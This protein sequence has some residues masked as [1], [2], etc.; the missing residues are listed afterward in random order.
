VFV[1]GKGILSVGVCNHPPHR[2][3]PR[4]GNTIHCPS[5]APSG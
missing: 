2:T 1:P 5:C 3:F 4:R